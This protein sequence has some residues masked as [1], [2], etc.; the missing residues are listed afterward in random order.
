MKHRTS[1]GKLL[2]EPRRGHG[3]TPGRSR[4]NPAEDARRLDAAGRGS[5]AAL[6][7]AIALLGAT[8]VLAAATVLAH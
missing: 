3:R 4:R 8:A 2:I 5:L 1:T 6:P 7:W